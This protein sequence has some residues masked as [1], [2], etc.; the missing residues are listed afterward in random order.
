MT[1]HGIL[2]SG[3]PVRILAAL[4]VAF[5][6]LVAVPGAANAAD[7]PRADFSG[8]AATA[9]LSTAEAK[10]LQKQVDG[11][12]ASTHG[13]QIGANKIALPGGG[14][15]L[16]PLPGERK[17]RD[18]DRGLAAGDCPYQYV[19]A[20][21]GENYTGTQINMFTCNY[22][23]RITWNTTGSW[24]NNQRAELR[25]RFYD[26][27]GAVGWVSPG[28]FSYDPHADWRWVWWVSPC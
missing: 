3:G 7:G 9:G 14:E 5:L 1:K 28:G 23:Y 10:G 12:L 27:N 4:V 24:I 20:Y 13:T 19:C 2:R 26:R 21:Y 25:A 6:A 17:A 15:M 22:M 18:L 16:L 8:Q 11:A